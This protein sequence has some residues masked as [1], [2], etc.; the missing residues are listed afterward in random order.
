VE[1][2]DFFTATA[3]KLYEE[4]DRPFQADWHLD[5]KA[6]K[7]LIRKLAKVKYPL[8][9]KMDDALQCLVDRYL[10]PL[11]KVREMILLDPALHRVAYTAPCVLC[12]RASLWMHTAHCR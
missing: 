9:L 10:G 7:Q 6:F 1:T 11:A 2:D 8:A 5:F 3:A 12:S 4:D